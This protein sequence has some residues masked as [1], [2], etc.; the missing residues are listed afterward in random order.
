MPT[1]FWL[2]E[3]YGEDAIKE[4]MGG[5]GGGGMDDIFSSMFGGGGGRRQQR[6]RRGE[7]VVHRLKVSLD[8]MYNGSTR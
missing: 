6:E 7:N 5:G 8:E 3:Q 4:G 1:R 2:L